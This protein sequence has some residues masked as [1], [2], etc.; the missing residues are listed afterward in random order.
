[1]DI[2][3]QTLYS[4]VNNSTHG[5]SSWHTTYY[6][7]THQQIKYFFNFTRVCYL[8]VIGCPWSTIPTCGTKCPWVA[9]WPFLMSIHG[10]ALI[11]SDETMYFIFYLVEVTRTIHIIPVTLLHIIHLI[12]EALLL[13]SPL[14][15]LSHGHARY[16]VHPV[17]HR[18][19]WGGQAKAQIWAPISSTRQ[20]LS[21]T[22]T[23]SYY[24]RLTC[25]TYD[26]QLLHGSKEDEAMSVPYMYNSLHCRSQL[27]ICILL[28]PHH[29]H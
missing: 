2:D 18:P 8:Y 3:M 20:I 23:F 24:P 7:T 28:I 27:G 29:Q 21:N 17:I 15:D 16:M 9:L 5:A 4:I 6:I 14:P 19:L 10:V 11:V 12:T 22:V 1:M 26:K 13:S 25:V